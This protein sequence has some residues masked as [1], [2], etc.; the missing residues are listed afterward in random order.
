MGGER[1]V[2]YTNIHGIAGEVFFSAPSYT[3]Q[4]IGDDKQ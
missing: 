1:E 3:L 2:A 4:K